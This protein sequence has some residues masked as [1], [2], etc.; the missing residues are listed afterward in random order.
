MKNLSHGV[1]QMVDTVVTPLQEATCVMAGLAAGDLTQSM[2]GE[3]RGEFAV[4]RDAVNTSVK[5]LLRM[6]SDIRQAAA[7]VTSGT[8]EISKGNNDLSQRTQEQAA[9]LEET[10]S[11]IEEMTSTVK[12]NADNAR[13]ANQLATAA[14]EQAEKGGSVV[15][16]AVLAMEEINNS[17]KKIA[18]IIG[19]IDSI[20]FQTNLLALNAAVEA[21]RAGEQGRGFA[22]VAAE[23]RKLAQRSADAAKEIK[24]LINDSV[25]KVTHG[26]R[27]V[28][29]SGK[30]LE[31][32]VHAVKKVSD[33]I[34][35][36][37]AASQEQAAGIEQ[38]NKAI[39]QMDEVTQQNAALV[40]EMASAS[41]SLDEQSQNMQNLMRFFRVGDE[42][43]AADSMAMSSGKARLA[44]RPSHAE[45]VKATGQHE[46]VSLIARSHGVLRPAVKAN[47]VALE[48][49]SARLR[50]AAVQIDESEWQDF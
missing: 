43:P 45:V 2:D 10:A 9:S 7:A 48:H 38:V 13:Q 20:A 8:A 37:T 34:A 47:G 21:A 14:R 39:V 36:I 15:S 44:G 28:D 12:Q 25:E 22:V 41:E 40:E 6:V 18:D 11:S 35:E 33:I 46:R 23:V 19:V 27:L 30:V 50:S 5:N 4:L 24:N 49:K 1:N 17:S 29:E 42:E 31:E 26:T 16:K 3:F 32:I